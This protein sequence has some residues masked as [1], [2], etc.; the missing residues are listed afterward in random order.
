[1]VTARR[2]HLARRALIAACAP[3]VAAL[4]SACK[5]NLDETV[6]LITGPTMLAVQIDPPETNPMAPATT[7]TYKALFV[8]PSGDLP[9]AP[10]TWAFCN[11]REPLAELGPV[12]NECLQSSGSWFVPVGTGVDVVTDAGLPAAA[13]NQFGPDVPMVLQGQTPG[14][15]VDPDS[16]GGYY[17][18]IRFVAPGTGAATIGVAEERI[19]CG[20]SVGTPDQL[21]Q[22]GAQYHYNANPAVKSLSIV[23]GSTVGPALVTDANRQTNPVTA[24]QHI[25][26]EV[27]WPTCPTVDKCGDDICGPDETASS[28]ATGAA[29]IGNTGTNC[30][31][32]TVATCT[33]DC[34]PPNVNGC[35]GAERFLNFDLS[36]QCLVDARESIDVAW[37][38]TGGAFDNDRTGRI[39][40]DTTTTSDNGWQAPSSPG[41]VTLWVVLRDDRGGAGWA[42][43]QLNVQ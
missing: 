38:A 10:I 32:P 18:P 16:T 25:T 30:P 36:S 15:P 33:A 31:P 22:F 13:C 9:G 23:S 39:D 17:Q 24:G 21:G 12:N 40:T 11:A 29:S 7:A 14:R 20:L 43:Y 26:L 8:G 2:A 42:E 6:S 41:V 28:T 34:V 3:A 19:A 1:M 4:A 5:P 37:F 35:G 27:A